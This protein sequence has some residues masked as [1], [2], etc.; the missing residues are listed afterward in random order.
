MSKASEISNNVFLG[1]TPDPNLPPECSS[2]EGYD[3]LIEATDLAHVPESRSLRALRIGLEKFQRKT[4]LHME[5]PSS[6]SIMLPS[7]SHGEVDG[8][9]DMCKW[10]Y[11]LANPQE[12]KRLKRG[13]EED[14]EAIAMNDVAT[15]RKF[16]DPLHGWLYRDDTPCTD[17]LYVCR[18]TTSTRCLDS[19]ASCQRTQLLCIPI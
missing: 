19:D 11:E 3:M 12:A 18:R 6:G 13:R 5:F 16:F 14:D 10:I 9:M 7:W 15:P 1:P 2:E 4:P 8:L 17:I